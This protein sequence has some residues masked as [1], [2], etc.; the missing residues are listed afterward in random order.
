MSEILEMGSNELNPEPFAQYEIRSYLPYINSFNNNDVIR[1]CIQ[2]GEQYSVP[3][4]SQ[5][6]I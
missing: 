1:I 4:K 3:N 5:L 6:R 2:H